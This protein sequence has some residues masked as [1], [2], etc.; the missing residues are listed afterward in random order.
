MWKRRLDERTK[1]R[2]RDDDGKERR[3][4]KGDSDVWNL[5]ATGYYFLTL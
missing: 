2:W 3:R 1:G 5:Q 4:R